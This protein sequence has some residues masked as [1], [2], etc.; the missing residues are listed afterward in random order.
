MSRSSLIAVEVK[1]CL[2]HYCAFALDSSLPV[3][4]FTRGNEQVKSRFADTVENESVRVLVT[5]EVAW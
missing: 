2:E 1:C 4:D 5:V 3:F